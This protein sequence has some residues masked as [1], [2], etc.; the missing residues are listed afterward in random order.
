MEINGKTVSCPNC[1][2]WA[3]QQQFDPSTPDP[4]LEN[5]APGVLNPSPDVTG[6]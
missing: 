1:Q 2:S 5:P 3:D 4:A 6:P